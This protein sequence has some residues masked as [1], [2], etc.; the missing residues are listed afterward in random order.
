M[1]IQ[2]DHIFLNNKWIFL[3]ETKNWDWYIKKDNNYTPIK[4][5]ELHNH[6]FYIYLKN[7]LN[8]NIF[9]KTI[10]IP[11]IY[12]LIIFTGKYKMKSYNPYIKI[13]TL[14]ELKYFINSRKK[15]LN[16][17][18]VNEISTKLK[19]EFNKKN[20]FTTSL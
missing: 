3:I 5:A 20:N 9:F 10:K 15:I 6:A 8:K 16:E 13:L 1:S 17:K 18:E 4:Q 7:I 11:K 2:I 12:N 19:Y 14:N